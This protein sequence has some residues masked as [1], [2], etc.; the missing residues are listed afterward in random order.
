MGIFRL[1]QPHTEEYMFMWN[2]LVAMHTFGQLSD[3]K[4]DE[5]MRHYARILAMN[6]L[7][8]LHDVAA[9][10]DYDPFWMSFTLAD[11]GVPPMLGPRTARWFYITNP[12]RARRLMIDNAQEISGKV[13]RDIQKK[14]GVTLK[15][16]E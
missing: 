2:S 12:R 4:K 10:A 7:D 6:N 9:L 14:Y 8:P 1:F 11:L 13:L 16:P 15:L 5:L 3:V